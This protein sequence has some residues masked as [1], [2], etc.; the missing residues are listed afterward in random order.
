VG[1]LGSLVGS[2]GSSAISGILGGNAQEDAADSRTSAG[3]EADQLEWQRNLDALKMNRINQSSPWGSITYDEQGNQHMSLDPAQQAQLD[4]LR[5]GQTSL[6]NSLSKPVG[7]FKQETGFDPNSDVMNAYR[8]INQPLVDQQ[9]GKENARLAAMGLGTGSGMAW[10][11]AQDALNR[12]QVNSDQNAI[13]QGFN[14]TQALRNQ[15]R[16]DYETNL[17]GNKTNAANLGVLGSQESAMRGNMTGSLPSY[18]Q[19]QPPGTNYQAQAGITNANAQAQQS[20]NNAA[21]WG[22]AIGNIG[23]KLIDNYFK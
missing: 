16:S 18:A 14:A 19:M 4:A 23:G 21:G 3:K 5:G 22:N 13:L 11:T 9:R 17:S 8:A 6:I 15:N 1:S 2:L 10:G 12:N 20:A 7:E